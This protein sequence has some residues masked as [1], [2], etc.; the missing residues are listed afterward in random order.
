MSSCLM[1]V[2]CNSF[3]AS[4]TYETKYVL[5]QILLIIHLKAEVPQSKLHVYYTFSIC[6]QYGNA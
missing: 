5:G 4:I 3:K 6:S 1:F 2:P